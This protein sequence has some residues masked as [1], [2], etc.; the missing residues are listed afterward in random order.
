MTKAADVTSQ[1]WEMANRLRG[2]MDASEYRNYILGF[3]FYRY[4]SERQE[5]YLFENQILEGINSIEEVNEEYAK[6]ANGDELPDYL[7]DIAGSLGYAIEP[8][9]TWKTIVDKV[10]SS[11]IKPDTF[12]NMFDSFNN[13]LRLNSRATQDFTGVFNDMNLNNSRLGTTTATRAKSLTDIVGIIDQV[14]YKDESGKDIL[15]DIYEFLIAMFAGNS[16]KK[17][18]EFYT[19]HQVSEV[20]AKLATISLDQSD[21][22]PSVYDFACGSGS[23]LLTV[24]EEI[25]NKVLYFGQELNTTTYN[26]ARMN[27]M[28]HCVP[29]DRMTLNN[30]DTLEEDWPSKTD[31]QGIE[32]PLNFDVVVANPP[33]SQPW[34][35]NDRKLKD[36]RFKDYGLAP[37]TKADYAFLLHG[38]YH[39]DQSG[40]MAIVLPHG[41]L[42]RGAKEGK[43]RETLLKKNQI[44]AIIGLPAGLFYS[45]G[46]PTVVL[47]LKKN[48]TNRNVLFIDASK[49]FEKGKRQN[50]LRD[51]DINKIIDTYKERKDVERYAHVA[52][53]DEIEENDFNLNIPRYVDTFVPEPPVDLKKVAA[54]LHETNIEI[55][56]TQK[57]LVRMLKD[58]TSDDNDIMEGLNAIIKELGEEKHD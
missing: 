45:T 22:K 37:K 27:L 13:N 28:M 44:D 52:S 6:E 47:V 42:F 38:L 48:K 24:Q 31:A 41:V 18:G 8:K 10:N 5:K 30:A 21:P 26:L 53:F 17:A 25:N 19:P 14:S 32:H 55:E 11:T 12:Q 57:E 35:N 50:S 56:K 46:I 43:I 39:L 29:Y 2:N 58:L 23:L 49:G 40:T 1:I 51:E 9:Y 3:M 15:A 33:Y 4:L 7:D 20:L 36:P 54:D 16:G 34:D